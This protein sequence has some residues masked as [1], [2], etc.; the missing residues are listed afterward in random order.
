MGIIEIKDLYKNYNNLQVLKGIDL[1]INEGEVISIIGSSGSGKSTLLRS[2]NLLEIPQNGTITFDGK[3]IFSISTNHLEISNLLTEIEK[4][5]VE[6]PKSLK[7]K[8]LEKKLKHEMKIQQK[9]TDKKV[10]MLEKNINQYRQKVGMVFQHFNIFQNLSVI[11]NITL[12]PVTLG[13]IEKEEANKMALELLK[14]VNLEDKAY[15]KPS[16]LSGGQ[17]QRIAIV[18]SLAMHPNVLLFDEPTS[19]LDPEMV[20]EVLNVIKELANQGM[21][22]VIVTH[23]MGFAKEVSDKVIFMDGGKIKVMGTPE[24]VFDHPKDERLVQFLNAVL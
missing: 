5:K 4:L 13:L 8:E 9:I 11:D 2:I 3:E 14:R 23:E 21:T 20:K 7:L 16:S 6:D 15:A 22:M 12:A 10:S 19:A 24:E 17:L 18:R 1:E